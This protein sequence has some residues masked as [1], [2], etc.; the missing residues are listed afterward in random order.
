MPTDRKT[1]AYRPD[2]TERTA[3]AA[4]VKKTGLSM[5]RLIG[6]AVREKAAREGVQTDPVAVKETVAA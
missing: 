5:S 2:E 6:L 3:L 1:L 4:L